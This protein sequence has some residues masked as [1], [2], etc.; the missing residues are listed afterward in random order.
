MLLG[1]GSNGRPYQIATTCDRHGNAGQNKRAP[2]TSARESPVTPAANP[3]LTGSA[4]PTGSPA[5][6]GSADYAGYLRR[7]GA[8]DNTDISQV[9]AEQAGCQSCIASQGAVSHL[10]GGKQFLSFLEDKLSDHKMCIYL[11]LT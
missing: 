7:P 6:S 11:C 8:G 3:A 4:A 10:S 2:L 5:S 9:G 1:W